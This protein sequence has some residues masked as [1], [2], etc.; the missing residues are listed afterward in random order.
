[1]CMM[2]SERVRELVLPASLLSAVRPVISKMALLGYLLQA[3]WKLLPAAVAL[4][5]SLPSRHI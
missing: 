4:A 1:M 2:K 3:A 5:V